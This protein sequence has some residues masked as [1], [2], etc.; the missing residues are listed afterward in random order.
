MFLREKVKKKKREEKM[1]RLAEQQCHSS[2]RSE[3]SS[4]SL[5][6]TV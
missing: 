1:G 2:E 4:L 5:Q 6:G 3:P